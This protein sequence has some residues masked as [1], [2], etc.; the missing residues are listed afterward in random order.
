MTEAAEVIRAGTPGLV[1][2]NEICQDDAAVLER[3]FADVHG[4]GSIASA[5]TAAGNRPS[6]DATRCRNGRPYGIG[7]AD[8]P[9]RAAP[10]SPR[11]QRD[12]PDAGRRRP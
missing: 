1:T 6:G 5:F 4:G 10:G 12:A 8:P 7:F 9:S 11:A 3:T 2:L